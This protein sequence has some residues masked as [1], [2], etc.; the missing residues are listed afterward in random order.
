M[1]HLSQPPSIYQLNNIWQAVYMTKLL[2]EN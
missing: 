2:S 1:P